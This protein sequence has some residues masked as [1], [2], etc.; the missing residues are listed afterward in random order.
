MPSG[1]HAYVCMCICLFVQIGS[2]QRFE[3]TVDGGK[4]AN[5][6]AKL[7]ESMRLEGGAILIA[8]KVGDATSKW[9]TNPDDNAIMTSLLRPA[10]PS[11]T[12][13][14]YDYAKDLAAGH[15]VAAIVYPDSWV[16]DE[17]RHQATVA[18][19]S[20]SDNMVLAEAVLSFNPAQFL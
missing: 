11:V 9:S 18:M 14:P 16:S 8:V 1:I 6:F 5:R 12:E 13:V 10:P 3:N 20:V 17:R 7:A 15:S 4:A 2:T 19:R